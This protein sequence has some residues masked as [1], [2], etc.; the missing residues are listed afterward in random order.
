MS[1]VSVQLITGQLLVLPG[2][3][4]ASLSAPIPRYQSPGAP[5]GPLCFSG[6]CH[7]SLRAHHAL[8]MQSF[9]AYFT[10]SLCRQLTWMEKSI[11]PHAMMSLSTQFSG[12]TASR[13]M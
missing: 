2:Q 5:S 13:S 8:G 10:S 3:V 9:V 7:A 6:T 4:T 12:T 1:S 11:C